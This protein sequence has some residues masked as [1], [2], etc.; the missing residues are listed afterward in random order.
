ML[1]K[2]L[3]FWWATDLTLNCTDIVTFFNTTRSQLVPCMTLVWSMKRKC[4]TCFFV[5]QCIVIYLAQVVLSFPEVEIAIQGHGAQFLK[6]K[7]QHGKSDKWLKLRIWGGGDPGSVVSEKLHQDDLT[8][9]LLLKARAR[10]L[11]LY[12]LVYSFGMSFRARWEMWA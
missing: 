9:W 4:I 6:R 1:N 7:K 2:Y 12:G 11:Q 8:L 10:T 3:L 5:K